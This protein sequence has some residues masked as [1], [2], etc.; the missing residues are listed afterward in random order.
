MSVQ[1]E[2]DMDFQQQSPVWGYDL[3]KPEDLAAFTQAQSRWAQEFVGPAHDAS[4]SDTSAAVSLEEG[5]IIYS[6]KNDRFIQRFIANDGGEVW[7]PID[8]K[9]ITRPSSRGQ[10]ED[11]D[12]IKIQL[13]GKR[14]A[15]H[16][17]DVDLGAKV[18]AGSVVA[19]A[20]FFGLGHEAEATAKHPIQ[21]D[22]E[23]GKNYVIVKKGD[24]LTRIGR[25]VGQTPKQL[26]TDNGIDPDHIEVGQRL[27]VHP[28]PT[29]EKVI[30]PGDTL[31][32]LLQS[33]GIAPTLENIQKA[34]DLSSIEDP[35]VIQP[36]RIVR[37]PAKQSETPVLEQSKTIAPL[38]QIIRHV[39]ERGDTLDG[40]LHDLG[41]PTKHIPEV[42]RAVAEELDLKDSDKIYGGQVFE[43]PAATINGVLNKHEAALQVE[44]L[45]PEA[46]APVPPAV[47]SESIPLSEPLD[48]PVEA[49]S[50]QDVATET[51]AAPAA[52]DIPTP[53]APVETTPPAEEQPAVV[54]PALINEALVTQTLDIAPPESSAPPVEAEQPIAPPVQET[55]PTPEVAP[56]PEQAPATPVYNRIETRVDSQTGLE[57]THIDGFV[58]WRQG[59][60]RWAEHSYGYGKTV[61]QAG[62]GPT[63]F[64]MV[65]S[66]LGNQLITPAQM[67]DFSREHGYR[68]RGN[69]TKTELFLENDEQ[70]GIHSEFIGVDIEKAKDVLKSGGL[71]IMSVGDEDTDGDTIADKDISP[72]TKSTG[73]IVVLRGLTEDGRI[74]VGDPADRSRSEKEWNEED[75]MRGLKRMT[76]ITSAKT[77][78]ER[79]STTS[80]EVTATGDLILEQDLV[81]WQPL[82]VEEAL[83]NRNSYEW[84][85]DRKFGPG[86]ELAE[87]SKFLY[88]GG[89][90]NREELE[91]IT[92][93]SIAESVGTAVTL[94]DGTKSYLVHPGAVGDINIHH[95][96]DMSAGMVQVYSSPKQGMGGETRDPAANLH[97]L[98]NAR[99]ANEIYRIQGFKAWTTYNT[100]KYKDY[101]EVAKA[102]VSSALQEGAEKRA[103]QAELDAWVAGKK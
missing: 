63:T 96:G 82:T 7:A 91:I 46:P 23:S 5:P 80:P 31:S 40:L 28:A 102:R 79:P 42:R 83:H 93:I 89:F 11:E 16:L 43:I 86:L 84:G 51:P 15:I 54:D 69:G 103:V 75:V 55:T 48:L 72:L 52:V 68:V 9:E 67:A 17:P 98:H 88:V 25:E 101:L 10:S 99:A 70:F 38:P 65:V 3:A 100:G 1:G 97:P 36:G 87:A 22:A 4:N 56:A 53:A 71:V 57:V 8:E 29:I 35:D 30:A 60:S 39:V 12:F 92:A 74:L 76:A 95:E 49:A 59:D 62:C 64:A 77:V 47:V 78:N 73:H 45:Q 41:V 33:E 34:A 21:H 90:K 6:V 61:R 32:K 18:I 13:P 50:V 81:Q 44:T 37:L 27:E 19:A 14:A 58:Y 20:A 24:N 66:T 2:A 94:P 26:A 85:D